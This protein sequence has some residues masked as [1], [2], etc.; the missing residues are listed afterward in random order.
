MIWREEFGRVCKE[1]IDEKEM[2]STGGNNGWGDGV[3]VGG[4]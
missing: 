4:E 3:E 1:G 2:E